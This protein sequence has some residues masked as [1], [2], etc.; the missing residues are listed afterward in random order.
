MKSVAVQTEKL[1]GVCLKVKTATDFSVLKS[2]RLNS[3]CKRCSR[4]RATRNRVSAGEE[5]REKRKAAYRERR[6]QKFENVISFVPSMRFNLLRN[7][8]YCSSCLQTK[9]LE[10]FSLR[11]TKDGS[12]RPMTICKSCSLKK[13]GSWY[14]ANSARATAT[15]KINVLRKQVVLKLGSRCANPFCMI[16][17]RCSD[18]R[19]L[20]I[21]HVNNDG[22]DERRKY[23][24]GIGPEGGQT[25]MPRSKMAIIY[26]LALN[27]TGN[28]YQLLCANCNVIKEY[29][30][31]QEMYRQRKEAHIAAS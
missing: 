8:R 23:G 1:C 14:S 16:P 7:H 25:P 26:T 2:G 27:D 9:D 6:I 15:N 21:D 17:G 18:V 22:A 24:I 29:E 10:C 4:D 20:Q 28:R 13:S 30:R 31:R 3:E 11:V 5:G 12:K 19:A